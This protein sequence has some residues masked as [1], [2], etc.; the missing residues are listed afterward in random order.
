MVAMSRRGEGGNKADKIT[1][2]IDK[3]RHSLE[4]HKNITSTSPN[5]ALRVFGG[6]TSHSDVFLLFSTSH[7]L[8]KELGQKYSHS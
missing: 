1:P 3:R 8:I 2:K 5:A 6:I 7:L 4:K